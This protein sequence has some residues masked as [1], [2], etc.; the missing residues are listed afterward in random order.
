MWAQG[1]QSHTN[2]HSRSL[3]KF[4]KIKNILEANE[5]E[6]IFEDE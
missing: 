5:Y 2:H 4:L 1:G 6:N 3:K